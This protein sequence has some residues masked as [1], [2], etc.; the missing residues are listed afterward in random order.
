M[1]P[2]VILPSASSTLSLLF[3]V[4]LLIDQ[5]RERRRPYQLVWALGMLWYG[6]S[7]ATE[8]IGSAVGW[9]EPLYR[10]VCRSPDTCYG[11]AKCGTRARATTSRGLSTRRC[12]TAGG[13]P[14]RP[15]TRTAPGCPPPG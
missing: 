13:H 4:L 8:W 14:G 3:F 7:A 9:S 11:S 10:S 2:N 12:C 15:T 1:D 6:L 5:W